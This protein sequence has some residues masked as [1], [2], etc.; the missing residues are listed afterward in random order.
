MH[1]CIRVCMYA[2]MHVYIYIYML[3]PWDLHFWGGIAIFFTLFSLTSYYSP[4]CS[5]SLTCACS[6]TCFFYLTLA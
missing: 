5:Y 6:P 3:P 4:T 2:C 1:M